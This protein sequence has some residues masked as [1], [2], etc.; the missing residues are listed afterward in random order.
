M[1]TYSIPWNS[2]C[3]L[4]FL[5]LLCISQFCPKEFLSM[6]MNIYVMLECKCTSLPE[7]LLFWWIWML[8]ESTIELVSREFVP[9]LFGDKET[10]GRCCYTACQS[11]WQMF[12]RCQQ[13]YQRNHTLQ[14]CSNLILCCYRR[15]WLCKKAMRYISHCF[16]NLFS[17]CHNY[18]I[19]SGSTKGGNGE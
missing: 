16:R 7:V 2:S 9:L 3:S 4:I 18:R 5:F 13:I 14:G 10:T 8:I 6:H 11:H 19:E 17:I 15:I 12:C 1:Y